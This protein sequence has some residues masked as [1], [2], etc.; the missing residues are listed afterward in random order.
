VENIDT[1]KDH[2]SLLV[3][4]GNSNLIKYL[5]L[6]LDKEKF[7]IVMENFDVSNIFTFSFAFAYWR[8]LNANKSQ[9]RIFSL[10]MLKIIFKLNL[11]NFYLKHINKQIN[12]I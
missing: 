9:E 3:Q 4:F 8:N 5:D 1:A 10:A 7:I 2:A 11:I 6:F 12:K